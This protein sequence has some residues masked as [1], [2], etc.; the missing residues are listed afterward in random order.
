LVQAA[1]IHFT[2]RAAA[3]ETLEGWQ[4]GD[5]QG[6]LYKTM[7]ERGVLTE[8]EPSATYLRS[9]AEPEIFDVCWELE[10]GDFLGPIEIFGE[11]IIGRLAGKTPAGPIPWEYAK[12]RVSSDLLTKRKE[13]RLKSLL[14]EYRERYPVHVDEGVLAGSEL[15]KVE[16]EVETEA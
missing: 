9:E 2:D 8:W 16:E 6:A 4:A 7:K 1:L 11:F 12:S 5:D 13:Q 14:D 10:P 3:V 15:L